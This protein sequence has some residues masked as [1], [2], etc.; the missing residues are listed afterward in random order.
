MWSKVNTGL[1]KIGSVFARRLG[2]KWGQVT[3]VHA[4]AVLCRTTIA[5]HEFHRYANHEEWGVSN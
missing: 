2:R 1:A 5:K 4:T 3:D